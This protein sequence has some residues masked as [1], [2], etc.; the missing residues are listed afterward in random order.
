MNSENVRK[1]YKRRVHKEN[2]LPKLNRSELHESRQGRIG[3]QR[4]KLPRR[5]R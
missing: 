2:K 4:S 5:N 3:V 1:L